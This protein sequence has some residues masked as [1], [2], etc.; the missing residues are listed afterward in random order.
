MAA[1]TSASIHA[2]TAFAGPPYRSHE[3]GVEDA[4]RNDYWPRL[5]RPDG[6][7]RQ[8]DLLASGGNL[9]APFRPCED[10]Q[11]SLEDVQDAHR[12]R[13]LYRELQERVEHATEVA[14]ALHDAERIAAFAQGR[15][16]APPP[17]PPWV[18][19]EASLHAPTQAQFLFIPGPPP[20]EVVRAT[21]R[22]AQPE[23]L[24]ARSPTRPHVPL[25]PVR[26]IEARE[27]GPWPPAAPVV[28]GLLPALHDPR[29]PIPQR[30][31]RIAAPPA[32]YEPITVPPAISFES[33]RRPLTPPYA[34]GPCVSF[35]LADGR[36][37]APRPLVWYPRP[38]RREYSHEVRNRAMGDYRVNQARCQDADCM[39]AAPCASC[40]I[41]PAAA[42]FAPPGYLSA[43]NTDGE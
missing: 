10:T 5:V 37:S 16:W 1:P 22:V 31:L 28:D 25:P 34:P 8:H 24:Q 18:D 20:H 39:L 6:S 41:H 11:P 33:S 23:L 21:T 29:P 32:P 9:T 26:E 14:R 27:F 42:F 30:Y 4:L 43:L 7:W 3:F 38:Y 19:E 17:N 40:I 13:A 12:D 15:A 36:Q 35:T 2:Q